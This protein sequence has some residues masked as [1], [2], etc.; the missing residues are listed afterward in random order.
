METLRMYNGN[1]QEMIKELPKIIMLGYCNPT[2]LKHIENQTGLKFEE[3]NWKNYEAQP[4]DSNQITRLFL[5][6]NFKTRYY[7]NW[8]YKNTMM[9]KSDHHIGFDVDAICGHC[10]DYNHIHNG[11]MKPEEMLCC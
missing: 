8:N 4:T 9:V 2:A 1:E 11:D 6:Y 5:T 7:D 3:N 10:R